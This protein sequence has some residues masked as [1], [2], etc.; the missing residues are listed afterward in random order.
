ML[1]GRQRLASPV[2]RMPARGPAYVLCEGD[3]KRAREAAALL[4][5]LPRMT[6][7]FMI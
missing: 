6:L 2:A 3:Q 4:R 7:R 1:R 5:A